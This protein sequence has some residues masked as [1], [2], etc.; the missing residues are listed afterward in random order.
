M[1]QEKYTTYIDR[2]IETENI[3]FIIE[4]LFSEV[5]ENESSGGLTDAVDSSCSEG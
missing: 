4:R 5:N 2:Y 3:N 1:Y